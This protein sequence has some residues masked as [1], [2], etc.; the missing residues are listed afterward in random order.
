MLGASV[1]AELVAH[2]KVYRAYV[3][4]CL[5]VV[6]QKTNVVWEASKQIRLR[7][8]PQVDMLRFN[9]NPLSD[10]GAGLLT[11]NTTIH[12][13]PLRTTILERK[14]Q[15]VSCFDNQGFDKP[16]LSKA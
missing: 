11:R 1:S 7:S 14:K 8:P 15:H 13:E 2:T 9:A 3:V 10:K 6:L 4:D 5:V 16:S 12:D